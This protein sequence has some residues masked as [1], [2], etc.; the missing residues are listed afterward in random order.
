MLFGRQVAGVLTRIRT[1]EVVDHRQEPYPSWSLCPPCSFES[2]SSGRAE[3]LSNI[4]TSQRC[5]L[6]FSSLEIDVLHGLFV[7]LVSDQRKRN[8]TRSMIAQ[9]RAG[10]LHELPTVFC[11]DLSTKDN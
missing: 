6:T 8:A 1:F 2:L 11:S 3:I 10:G 7:E 4:E 9:L 5:S